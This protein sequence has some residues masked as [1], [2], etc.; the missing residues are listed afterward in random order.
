M[1]AP[2]SP[3]HTSRGFTLVEIIVS[4]VLLSILS[5]VGAGMITQSFSTTKITQSTQLSNSAARSA[6][7]R[8]AREIRE[9][10]NSGSLGITSMSATGITYTAPNFASS[11]TLSY[12]TNTISLT[13]NSTPSISVALATNIS[14]FKLQYYDKSW[15][16]LTTYTSTDQQAVRSVR[17]S[18]TSAPSDAN[19][20]SLVTQVSLRQI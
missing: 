10:S 18:I 7:E 19:P 14:S 11:K 2:H 3:N 17:I 1:V 13:L 15:N 4:L 16:E 5:V 9:I 20:I 6:L 12:G 8:M